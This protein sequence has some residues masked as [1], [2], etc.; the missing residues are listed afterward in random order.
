[1]ERFLK[2]KKDGLIDFESEE[3]KKKDLSN[4]RTWKR[5]LTS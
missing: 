1:M 3:E 2:W 5:N 4:Y